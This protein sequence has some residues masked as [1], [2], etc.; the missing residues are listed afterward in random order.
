MSTKTQIRNRYFDEEI[1]SAPNTEA[2]LFFNRP[3]QVYDRRPELYG[4]LTEPREEAFDYYYY[5]R[6]LNAYKEEYERV[7]KFNYWRG[8][9]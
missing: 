6:G 5:R 2:D 3:G 1:C 4:P 7:K 9:K 8:G